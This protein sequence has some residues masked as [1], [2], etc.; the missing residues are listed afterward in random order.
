MKLIDVKTKGRYLYLGC[1][2]R[3]YFNILRTYGF[4]AG[5]EIDVLNCGKN[6]YVLRILGS[7]YTINKNLAGV[8][9]VT[10][11]RNSG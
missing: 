4:L 8:I 9:N 3:T 11:R 6:S 2:D 7:K 1:D 10:L 5:M